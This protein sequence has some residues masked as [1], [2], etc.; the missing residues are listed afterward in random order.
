MC[1][2]LISRLGIGCSKCAQIDRDEF[3][4]L[5]DVVIVFGKMC[6]VYVLY[7]NAGLRMVIVLR[8][9]CSERYT[10]FVPYH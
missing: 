3:V 7:Y 2:V 5:D 6:Y 9:F 8:C 10:A 1:L 4:L